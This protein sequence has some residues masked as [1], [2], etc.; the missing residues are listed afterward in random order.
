MVPV[1]PKS[2]I[3]LH[4]TKVTKEQARCNVCSK[5]VKTSGNTTNLNSHLKRQ[6]S[7]LQQQLQL[8]KG[9]KTDREETNEK[10]KI[11]RYNDENESTAGCSG[12][13]KV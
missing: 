2:N 8:Q 6:H 10:V 5:T 4:F 7:M 13:N 9:K 1:P 12:I 3:W 11:M